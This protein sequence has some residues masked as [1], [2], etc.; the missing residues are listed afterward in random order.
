V[1]A[2]GEPDVTVVVPVYNTMPYLTATLESLVRQTLVTREGRTERLQVVAVDDGST[3]GS[4]AEL[5]AYAARHPGLFTVVHQENSGGP[6]APCNVGL[7]HARGRYVFFLG[8][9]DYFGDE[10][11]ERL[12]ARAD[13]WESDV[14]CAR[15]VGEG[16]R[17][18]NQVLYASDAQDVPFPSAELASAL[19]NTKLFRRSLLAD[20]GIRFAR[21]LKVGSDQ[22]FTIEAMLHARRISVL[23]DYDYYHA[24]KREDASNITYSSDWRSRLAGISAVVEHV[25]DVVGPGDG[26]DL[27]L[28]RHFS[29]EIATLLRRD[30][31]E[32]DEAEQAEL[33]AAVNALA[34]DYLTEPMLPRLRVLDRWRFLLARDDDLAR[35]RTLAGLDEGAAPMQVDG[36]R[37]TLHYPDLPPSVAADSDRI[38]RHLGAALGPATVALDGSDLYVAVPT[39]LVAPSHPVTRIALAHARDGASPPARSYP[40]DPGAGVLSAPAELRDGTLLARLDLGRLPDA[41]AGPVELAVRVQFDIGARTFGLPVPFGRSQAAPR[42]DEGADHQVTARADGGS[43]TVVD[44]VRPGRPMIEKLRARWGRKR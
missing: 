26:R 24:V 43:M 36:D 20:H 25:A 13:E 44:V 16:G 33:V 32:V 3:D 11:L 10:A 22:P 1:T 42:R 8:A 28:G 37:V 6:A 14:V 27:L 19:S 2:V 12:V 29:G 34:A 31:Y 35:L 17:W 4:G 40:R 41:A 9:D 21:D 15:I 30:F 18:V 38:G 23:G 39:T 7:E 5:D